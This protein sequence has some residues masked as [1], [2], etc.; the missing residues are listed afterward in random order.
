MGPAPAPG[1]QGEHQGKVGDRSDHPRCQWNPFNQS[2][3]SQLLPACSEAD[4]GEWQTDS[5]ADDGVTEMRSHLAWR[6]GCPGQLPGSVSAAQPLLS[7]VSRGGNAVS[8]QA[9][10]NSHPV[11]EL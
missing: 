1:P 6:S 8:C 10:G 5:G 7:E 9:F 3:S 4:V 11:T 2:H